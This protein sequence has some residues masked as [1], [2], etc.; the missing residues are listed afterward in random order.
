MV[1]FLS[2]GAS[3]LTIT[4]WCSSNVLFLWEVHTSDVGRVIG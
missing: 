2:C 3:V 4:Q 1:V